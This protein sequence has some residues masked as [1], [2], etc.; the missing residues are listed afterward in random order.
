[1]YPAEVLNFAPS[2]HLSGQAEALSGPLTKKAKTNDQSTPEPGPLGRVREKPMSTGARLASCVERM[3]SGSTEASAVE[4]AVRKLRTQY[5][6]KGG[7]ST[8]DLLAG[9]E[10]FDNSVKAEVFLGLDGGDVQDQ[11]LRKQI[12]RYRQ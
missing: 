4:R 11:W 8:G 9:N 2:S 5:R 10:I 1:M 12:Q 7:W 6:N 3:V